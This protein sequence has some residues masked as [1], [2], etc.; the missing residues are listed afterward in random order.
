M[1]DGQTDIWSVSANSRNALRIFLIKVLKLPHQM[2][3][4]R[5]GPASIISINEFA[6]VGE[7]YSNA[8]AARN[9]KYSLILPDWNVNAVRSTE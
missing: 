1:L 7:L 8:E 4:A 9:H 3:S 5:S 6:K 2:D